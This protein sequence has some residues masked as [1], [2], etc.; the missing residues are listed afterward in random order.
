MNHKRRGIALIFSH[1]N[2]KKLDVRVGGEKDSQELA[3]TLKYLGFDV[4]V[5]IDSDVK[6][7]LS[8]VQNGKHTFSKVLKEASLNWFFAWHRKSFW[9]DEKWANGVITEIPLRSLIYLESI[10]ENDLLRFQSFYKL[11]PLE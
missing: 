9:S 6:T 4:R 3:Q 7:I 11:F 10:F 5:Y 8:T 2:F 1:V